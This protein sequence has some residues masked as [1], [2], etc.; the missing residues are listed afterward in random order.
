MKIMCRPVRVVSARVAMVADKLRLSQTRAKGGR[1]CQQHYNIP[2]IFRPSY[3]S[4]MRE[5]DILTE[6]YSSWSILLKFT[7]TTYWPLY[8][9]QLLCEF[10]CRLKV[11][12]NQNDFMMTPFGPKSKVIVVR[13]SALFI[14]GQKS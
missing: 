8:P 4:D 11:S 10:L 13:I 1:S 5:V 3:S 14:V 2:L 12:K 9:S 6:T 7:C